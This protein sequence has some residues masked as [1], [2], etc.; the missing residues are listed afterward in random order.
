MT[1][2]E[3]EQRLAKL[4]AEREEVNRKVQYLSD[5]N[6]ILMLQGKYQHLLTRQEWDKVAAE[7]YANET[8]GLRHEASDSGIY[9]GKEGVKRFFD[10]HMAAIDEGCG[11]LALH[12]ATS[13]HIEIAKDGKTAKSVWFCPGCVTVPKMEF[14][15]WWYGVYIIDYVKENGVWKLW[16]VNASPF[17]I[18]PYE[19]KGWLQ[20]SF[21]KSHRDGHEDGDPTAF[22]PYDKTKTP[23]EMFC[24]LPDIE[25]YDSW[26]E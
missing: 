1:M 4:E 10:T 13:P 15:G 24:H 5:M 8:P 19:G 16:H 2:E 20:M 18:T 22:N 21:G 7:C 11:T 6:E 17:F 12:M 9:C 14:N 3:L 26:E 23:K 25:P